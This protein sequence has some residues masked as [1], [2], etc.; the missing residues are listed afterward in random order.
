MPL[1]YLANQHWSIRT[2]RI[3]LAGVVLIALLLLTAA[4]VLR[5]AGQT[6]LNVLGGLALNLLAS[7]LG[8][9]AAFVTWYYLFGPTEQGS[10][11]VI[12]GRDIAEANKVATARSDWFSYRG[13]SGHWNLRENLPV[14]LK[15]RATEKGLFT[16]K[17]YLPSPA[18][19]TEKLN[20]VCD[21][22]PKEFAEPY[23][24]LR[25]DVLSA[26]LELCLLR[27]AFPKSKSVVYFLSFF[28]NVRWDVCEGLALITRKRDPGVVV[29]RTTGVY[30]S[31]REEL[32]SYEEASAPLDVSRW[33]M[34]TDVA[35]A[36]WM[37]SVIGDLAKLGYDFNGFNPAERSFLE[38]KVDQYRKLIASL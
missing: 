24:A 15:G 20:Y 7:A 21:H 36:S 34:A 30:A 18:I 35:S 16:L 8:A 5:S 4:Y 32:Q 29:A 12:A 13:P 19:I 28:P 11:D 3:W 6:F 17:Y 9:V 22:C 1:S 33:C 37:D 27:Q 23:R 38:G 31:I 26:V 14:V 25:G 2:R 10:V